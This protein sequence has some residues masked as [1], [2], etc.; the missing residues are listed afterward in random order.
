[1]A[2]VVKKDRGRGR[3]PLAQPGLPEVQSAINRTNAGVL[4]PPAFLRE[5]AGRF[6]ERRSSY[7]SV[8]MEERNTAQLEAARREQ[9]DL[10]CR[11]AIL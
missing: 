10:S 9:A 1:M 2:K 7:P 6:R 4:T 3:A 8:Q 11:K 5:R